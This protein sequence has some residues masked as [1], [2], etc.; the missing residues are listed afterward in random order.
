M[1]SRHL[2]QL[3]QNSRHCGHQI[4]DGA[5]IFLKGTMKWG[6]IIG[7]WW[8]FR[9][10]PETVAIS[11]CFP[12][13]KRFTAIHESD[14]VIA[15]PSASHFAY[16]R[17]RPQQSANRAIANPRAGDLERMQCTIFSADGIG[18]H[19][20]PFCDWRV[21]HAKP[22]GKRKCGINEDDVRNRAPSID[23]EK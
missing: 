7:T 15:E 12:N 8:V 17:D 14:A 20:E 13:H 4:G 22:T 18:L 5:V 3:I 23:S 19:R 1:E 6:E 9:S 21:L 2:A 10:D 11:P 16:T